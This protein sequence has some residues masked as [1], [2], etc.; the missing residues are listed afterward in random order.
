MESHL[1]RNLRK[2]EVVH[3]INENKLDNRIENLQ[4]TTYRDHKKLHLAGKWSLKHDCC[5]DCGGMSKKHTG[6]GLC[7]V[8]YERLKRKRAA[9]PISK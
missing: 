5:V 4:I 3:H 1:G 7:K 8:C 2:E 9:K 6:H